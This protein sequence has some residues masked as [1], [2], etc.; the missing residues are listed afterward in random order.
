MYTERNFIT[1]PFTA[2]TWAAFQPLVTNLMSDYAYAVKDS[3]VYETLDFDAMSLEG[4]N[5]AKTLYE[6]KY[7]LS[8]FF[9]FGAQTTSF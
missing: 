6:G 7:L 8:V 4:Y 1:R 9:A 5:I 2:E 3:S